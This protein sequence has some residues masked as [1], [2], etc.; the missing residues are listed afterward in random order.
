MWMYYVEEKEKQTELLEGSWIEPKVG[1][2]LA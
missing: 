1:W 2:R